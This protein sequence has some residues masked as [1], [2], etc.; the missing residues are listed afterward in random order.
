MKR[1]NGWDA[2]FLYSETP[3][4]HQHT[5]KIALIDTTEFAEQASFDV[6]VEVFRQR[7]HRLEP[8]S[9]QLVDIPLH[10]H[11]PMWRERVEIDLSYHIRH[12]Q[13]TAPG[14]RWELDKLIGEIASTP[15]DR[16]R[17]LS[18]M[19]YAEGIVG[20]K[21]AVIAK[22]HHA[23]AD[24]VASANLMALAME[25]PESVDEDRAQYVAD[26]SP[27]TLELLRAATVDHVVQARALPDALKS[28]LGGVARVRRRA[29]ERGQHPELAKNFSPPTTFMNH[30]L[31]PV[32]TFA[33][34]TLLLAEFKETSKH[35]RITLNDLVLA[36]SAG[37]LRELLL[38]RDGHAD[39]PIIAS[40]PASIDLSP[41]RISGNELSML[42]VSLPVQIADPLERVRVTGLAT[43]KGKEDHE[44]LGR[45]TIATLIEY[46]PALAVI[47]AFRVM[48]RREGPNSAINLTISNVPGP[49]ERGCI[50]GAVVSE[51]YSVGPLAVGSGINITVWSY[52]DQLEIS[53]L[54]DD[55]TL[56]EP[57]DATDAMIHAFAEIREASGLPKPTTA[58]STAMPQAHRPA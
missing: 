11:R 5:L 55:R 53:V 17:P 36:V 10:L 37:A 13:V 21:V 26:P 48:A 6:F 39:R 58:I 46:S 50:G 47:G 14:G 43:A 15:L 23:L 3:N 35:L 29:K 54:A 31:S 45:R 27:S 1:L 28:G 32:R 18:E 22:I 19:H 25:W 38:D 12:A 40:V 8:L 56:P 49:R 33:T 42:A 7:L 44:L 52:A 34:A 20:N 4:V 2:F 16:S 51:I 57:H 41:D 30:R 9:Y 24:G